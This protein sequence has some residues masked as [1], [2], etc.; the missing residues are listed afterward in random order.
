[1][2]TLIGIFMIT[3]AALSKAVPEEAFDATGT[4][5]DT[6]DNYAVVLSF[7]I[8]FLIG[9]LVGDF[10]LGTWLWNM[11]KQD[12]YSLALGKRIEAEKL[13][14]SVDPA[15]RFLAKDTF[16][17]TQYGGKTLRVLRDGTIEVEGGHKDNTDFDWRAGKLAA[18]AVENALP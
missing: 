18:S 14:A 1:L 9:G 7:G 3:A 13:W 10:A 2:F 17:Q 4:S 6:K 15:Q 11:N 5:T 8:I 12:A 16:Y